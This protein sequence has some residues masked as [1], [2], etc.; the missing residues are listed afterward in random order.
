MFSRKSP[1]AVGHLTAGFTSYVVNH[2]V[3][4][5]PSDEQN[6]EKA[7]NRSIFK[8]KLV[9]DFSSSLCS[10]NVHLTLE[11]HGSAVHLFHSC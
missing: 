10:V 11:E 2:C 3:I 9:L 8:C 6:V 7:I 5:G 1:F 4:K